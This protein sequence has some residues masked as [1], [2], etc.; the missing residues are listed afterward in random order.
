MRSNLEIPDHLIREARLYAPGRDPLDAVCHVLADYPRI[1]S[2]ARKLRSRLDQLDT[3]SS[4]LD[5]R[6]EALQSACRA[7]LDL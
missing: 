4:A 1:L 5:Q 2:E 3:E 7:I 6:L